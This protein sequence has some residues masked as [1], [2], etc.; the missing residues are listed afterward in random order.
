MRINIKKMFL[1]VIVTLTFC[2]GLL[3]LFVFNPSFLY[4]KETNHKNFTIHHNGKINQNLVKMLDKSFLQLENQDIFNEEAKINVCLNDGSIYP[5]LIQTLMGPDV[6]RSLANISVVHADKLDIENN[7]MVFSEWSNES[8]KASQWF[9]HSFTHCLQY[10]KFGFF[11]S[12]PVAKHDEWKWEGYAEYTSFGDH[13]NLKSLLEKHLEP[14]DNN[15]VQMK[16]GSKTSKD[17]FK[18]LVMI[19]YCIETR[20]MSYDQILKNQE[21]S[22]KIY[23]D[24]INWYRE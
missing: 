2:V 3:I 8:F 15:W 1:R 12:N 7:I 24:L 20:Q 4:A 11:G 13:Y 16:D 22:D 10:E 17:H 6:I 14:T 5:Q 19:K 23:S 9:T 21:P 18:F